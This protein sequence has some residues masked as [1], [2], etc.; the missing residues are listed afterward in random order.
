MPRKKKPEWAVAIE[1]RRTKLQLSQ[2][3]VAEKADMS[4]SYY[5][6]IERGAKTL[7]SLTVGKLL[8]LARALHWTVAEMQRATGVDLGI[9]EA[10]TVGEGS[11]DVYPLSAALNPEHPGAAIDHEAVVAGIQQPL[12]LRMDTDEMY[13]T[14]PA[15]I[16]PGD[17]LHVDRAHTSPEEGRVYVITDADGPHVRL[18]TTTRLGPVFRAENRQYEDIPAQEAQVVGL[19]AGVTS[20]YNPQLLN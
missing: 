4:Q 6:D 10:S 15:S 14:T 16:R 12:L 19:V 9:A 17:Y 8:G 18:Y 2:E 7:H 3:I 20:D 1:L 11:A 5:S 13:G